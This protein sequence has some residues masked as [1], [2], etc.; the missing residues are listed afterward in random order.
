MATL[1]ITTL[2]DEAFGGGDLATETGDGNGLSLREALALAQDGD[3][4]EFDGSL[5]GG[6]I[7]LGGTQLTITQDDL[8]ID[9]DLDDDGVA[10]ITISGNDQS[11]VFNIT[12][13]AS[14]ADPNN[15]TL[16]GLNISDGALTD[17]NGGAIYLAANTDV[18]VSHSVIDG[19]QVT[20][21]TGGVYGGAI[22]GST[23]S[24]IVRV[25]DSVISNNAAYAGGGN[26]G[27][28]GAISNFGQSYI[29]NSEISGNQADSGGA[30]IGL[31]SLF[32]DG[33]TFSN[34]YSA[35]S[36][37]AIF[38]NSGNISVLRSEFTGN[39]AAADGGAIRL[40]GGNN[41]VV[42]STFSGNEAINGGAIAT[43][44]SGDTRISNSTF[45]GNYA[46]NDGGAIA[47]LSST[48]ILGIYNS[49]F[50]GNLAGGYG[51]GISQDSNFFALSDS[52]VAG[53]ESSSGGDDIYTAS[54]APA[55]YL[56]TNLFS[57]AG[58]GDA[59]DMY[60]ADLTTV[61]DVVAANPDTGVNSG[62]LSNNG[63]DVQTVALN[64]NATNV[65]IDGGTG[66]VPQDTFDLDDDAD[67]SEDLPFD[68]RG[69]GFDRSSN[70]GP[71]IGAFEAQASEITYT[72]TTLDDET[73]D[74][75]DLAAEMADGDGLSLREAL[76]LGADG[77]NFVFDG[78]LAGGS[79]VLTEGQLTLTQGVNIS[80]DTDGDGAADITI[81]AGGLGRVFHFTTGGTSS[82]Y[83]LTIR[84]ANS[85]V[86]GGGVAVDFGAGIVLTIANSTITSNSG[87]AGG[88]IWNGGDLTV[89][90]TSISSNT[91]TSS[92]GGGLFNLGN[93]QLVNVSFGT[94]FSLSNGGAIHNSGTLSLY[95]GTLA[96]NNAL[97]GDG[98]GIYNS[99]GL[100]LSNSILVN[101][102]HN[103]GGTGAAGSDL[104]DESGGA[105]YSGTNIFT[106]S[107]SAGAYS[108][109]GV[110]Y[111]D[112][113]DTGYLADN[114]GV[115]ETIALK[116]SDFNP[117]L[118]AGDGALP[119]DITDMDGDGD[120]TEAIPFDARGQGFDRDVDIDG[121]PATPDVGAYEIQLDQVEA[122]SLIVTTL[123]DVV[124]SLDGETSLREALAFAEDGDTIT[125]DA[126]LSGG[127]ITLD[128]DE[129][130]ITQDDLTIDGD[131]D[132]DGVGDITVDADGAS[133]VFSIA[134][135]IEADFN[136]VEFI[137]LTITG[138][139]AVSGGGV[140]AAS[141]TDVTLRNVNV[142]GN[143]ASYGAGVWNGGAL[144]VLNTTVSNNDASVR[145]GGV[146]NSYGT[147]DVVNSTVSGNAG[148]NNGG[149]IFNYRGDVG[150]T[151]GTIVGNHTTGYGGGIYNRGGYLDLINTTVTGNDA[152]SNGGGLYTIEGTTNVEIINSL[153]TGNTGEGSA[154]D[155]LGAR[156]LSGG[157]IIGTDIFD[158][159]SDVGDTT[160]ADVFRDV[161]ANPDTGVSSGILAD[162]GG[163][164][165]TVALN[166]SG[167]AVDAGDANELP[168]DAFDLDGDAD[169]A[170]DLPVDARGLPRV[171]NGAVDLGAVEMPQTF[172]VDTLLDGGDDDFGGGTFAEEASD[173]GGLSLREALALAQDGDTITFDNSL[174]GMT[175]TLAGTQLTISNSITIDGDL[176]NNGSED[177]TI[178]ANDASR[179][180]E[181]VG[182]DEATPNDVDIDGLNITG[183]YLSDGSNGAG[184]LVNTDATVTIQNSYIYGNTIA[185]EG[186]GG[187][188][189]VGG[190]S[191]LNIVDSDISNNAAANYGGGVATASFSAVINIS[192]TDIT[193][194]EAANGGGVYSR[195]TATITEGSFIYMNDAFNGGGIMSGGN[196]TVNGGSAIGSN[197]A[198]TSGGGVFIEGTAEFDGAF[199]TGNSSNY[200]GGG[201]FNQSGDLTINNSSINDNY[202][203][204]FGGGVYSND[205]SSTI[206]TN[207]TVEGNRVS[208]GSGGGL[209]FDSVETGI[210]VNSTIS[211]NGLYQSG[212]GGGA[213][214]TG[215][216]S[217]D[218][219]NTTFYG[220]YT[221]SGGGGA[222]AVGVSAGVGVYNST[223]TGNGVSGGT[224]GAIRG[225]G[226]ATINVGNS[227]FAGNIGEGPDNISNP[228]ETS[229]NNNYGGNVFDD[230]GLGG[231]YDVNNA[232]I[233]SIFDN[234]IVNESTGFASG[235]LSDNGGPVDTVALNP[236]G[237][238]VNAGDNA[239]LPQDTF[240][241][242][243]DSLTGEDLP[244][245]ARGEDRIQDGTVD[246]GAFEAAPT[247]LLLVTTAA[248][249]G[250]ADAYNGG[251]LAAETADGGG[252][253]LFEALALAQNGDTIEFDAGLSGATIRTG[254]EFGSLPTVDQ[255]N[256]IIDGDIDNDGSADITIEL[257]DSTSAL[258]LGGG[259]SSDA[260]DVT[261]DGVN[262]TGAY[263]NGQGIST[264]ADTNLTISN[265][266]I[267]N[268]G[269]S[270]I[271]LGGATTALI[272][273]M[274]F[275]DN[276]GEYGGAINAGYY[277]DVSIMNSYFYGNNANQ[278]GAIYGG[279]GA[280]ISID[281]SNFVA[282]T[283]TGSGGAI[284]TGASGATVSVANSTFTGNVSSFDGG[285]IFQEG[286]EGS[287]IIN[288]TFTG[289]SS[290]GGRG[291]AVYLGGTDGQIAESSFVQNNAASN[292]GALALNNN[293]VDIAN[294]LFAG[295]HASDTGGGIDMAGTG[296]RTVTNSTFYGND[297]FDGGGG[298]SQRG[299]QLFVYSSTF[300]G[301]YAEDPGGAWRLYGASAYGY[302]ANTIFSG[303]DSDDS[304]DDVHAGGGSSFY[305]FGGNIFGQSGLAGGN[306]LYTTDIAF[307]FN[308]TIS[309]S[310][311]G[312]T[313]GRMRDNG[314][315]VLT[316]M[317]NPLGVAIDAGDLG[318]LPPDF[319]DID[320]D[321][322]AGETL[323]VDGRGADRV[324]GAGVDVGA[325]ELAIIDGTE[326]ADVLSTG[327]FSALLNGLGGGD[328]L[329]GEDGRDSISGGAG[330][331]TIFG[332]D[333]DDSLGGD[334]G[335]DSLVGGS[336]DDFLHGFGS[337]DSLGG[338][339]GNDDL[340][341]G[342][343]R[344]LLNGSSGNDILRGFEGDDRLF[345][346]GGADTLLGNDGNDSL[347][348]GG[349][350][351]RLKGDAGD[352]TL[353]G[354]FG[355]DLVTGGAGDDLFEFRQGHGNDTYDDF[356][357]G[358]GT[359]DAIELIAFG[360]AFDTFAEVIAAAS[361]NGNHT[362]IDFGGGDSILLL[363]VVVADLHE[364]DFL[365]S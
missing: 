196:L 118:E 30:V 147:L 255:D 310:Y 277:S 186:H 230:S 49:T 3:I 132:D 108:I 328:D 139:S 67:T 160:L 213:H 233:E 261:I 319:L 65:A 313:S 19:N 181:V 34:N 211:S 246:A 240:D 94:N 56:G 333:N 320:G 57:Q 63:G 109:T 113:L 256:L 326:N 64:S 122:G 183:G 167:D 300:T 307:V 32:I 355:D 77:N 197:T 336:G 69:A 5:A 17:G 281:G 217:V 14:G 100:T 219:V 48:N 301:N 4:I 309:N 252:L 174:S 128:G 289:N 334:A 294:T 126:S 78:S 195:G 237:V 308:E 136:D 340:R 359:D 35:G 335:R 330:D 225:Y 221:A 193:H 299:G 96:G 179:V 358:A 148:S 290:E 131:I 353:N 205:N 306:D 275:L 20:A 364:D 145:G 337:H 279:E 133:R 166:T 249:G 191:T 74:G 274:Q 258:N 315:L 36:G 285:A 91:A 12:A 46:S 329:S 224:G 53:N 137:G 10:D 272:S 141:D 208:E 242:D 228:G 66:V 1:T 251:D 352:D 357:A 54:G 102:T 218:F 292:G 254:A 209:M 123:D 332:G 278:G 159:A 175:I 282:N 107:S 80:G 345:G 276:G 9:G 259:S 231:L 163:P 173:G 85:G 143:E 293:N 361:D 114:G 60:V 260:Q 363:N 15:V 89:L 153:V 26:L 342:F 72:I 50:S 176:D 360:T 312:I 241:L 215:S 41:R 343:G 111:L 266:T 62:Q 124:D 346:G 156:T 13:G 198:S 8:T 88:G 110:D 321:M 188:V 287:S 121:V 165:Q 220:N 158:G 177:I 189:Y 229:V 92:T 187:G 27:Y 134:S 263:G 169:T 105:T 152:G 245:D 68:A 142:T 81:D 244:I 135:G 42:N 97:L 236:V 55:I 323:P 130:A 297:A 83:A 212:P 234:V 302:A 216:S 144:T 264:G 295:N 349:G 151:N 95:H 257:H 157:N 82:L 273:N 322:D 182:G 327:E 192:G 286:G 180:F 243:N 39:I 117:A 298:L 265:S 362:T 305:S 104:T 44:N 227:V 6:T 70:S 253:S 226:G 262:F 232:D 269:D 356:V 112:V 267:E 47:G 280:S 184:V 317:I 164:V 7:T 271:D 99:G 16:Y 37:G 98:G 270:A 185:S 200:R 210:V 194:N 206:I 201:I 59:Q 84:G 2:D 140:Y 155:I 146:F 247:Q 71:D 21:L 61:F 125:F 115:V 103:N 199:I 23:T 344:D 341:G 38:F 235:E 202:A 119:A 171:S 116:A 347:T 314:G 204:S 11:R 40:F 303:N 120:T 284:Y 52:I 161:G 22:F 248:S 311:T 170:E 106:Q 338:G 318:Q 350:V 138:G 172:V 149:G 93:A 214:V 45:A 86:D 324:T 75:G 24:S 190:N 239:N 129:L 168:A 154:D 43:S 31:T 18:V 150:V 316:A 101:N 288:S 76:A 250:G 304:D 203:S 331:D 291:G 296:V 178:D 58:A 90:N 51:G 73:F 283:T 351:D 354:R 79:L 339:A 207:T 25:Y 348:G 238:A 29:I 162:N 28:G 223:F 325:V 87:A 268:F 222:I 365:F 33:S 127:T